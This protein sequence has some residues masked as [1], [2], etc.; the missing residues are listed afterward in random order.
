MSSCPCD[1]RTR[2]W[3]IFTVYVY[4]LKPSEPNAD[5][6]D[7]AY[8]HRSCAYNG[9][10]G[11]II[12]THPG[13]QFSF[14]EAIDL[15]FTKDEEIKV[16]KGRGLYEMLLAEYSAIPTK[17]G[18]LDLGEYAVVN[19]APPVVPNPFVPSFR[20]YSYNISAGDE[21]TRRKRNRNRGHRRGD[22]H[23][24]EAHCKLE[25]NRDT[26]KCFLN[27]TRHTD[28]DSPSRSNR[29]WTPLGYAQVSYRERGALI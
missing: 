7:I 28:P 17:I 24:K 15:E 14:L 4:Q 6:S 13:L 8:E 29:L 25:R 21:I 27:A 12:V 26:W 19:T 20:V 18:D 3:A 5:V 16:A 2:S 10:L 9:T 22:R 23:E 11:L 1:F